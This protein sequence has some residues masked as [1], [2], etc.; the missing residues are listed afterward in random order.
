MVG[1]EMG[2]CFLAMARATAVSH[3]RVLATSWFLISVMVCT[4]NI[5]SMDENRSYCEVRNVK[6]LGQRWT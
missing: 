5:S 1:K 2:F 6:I 3:T 4:E